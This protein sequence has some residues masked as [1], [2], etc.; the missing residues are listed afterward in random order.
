MA[1]PS[2]SGADILAEWRDAGCSRTWPGT[3]SGTPALLLADGTGGRVARPVTRPGQDRDSLEAGEGGGNDPCHLHCWEGQCGGSSLHRV[4]GSREG[5]ASASSGSKGQERTALGLPGWTRRG[6]GHG[7]HCVMP[8]WAQPQG[9]PGSPSRDSFQGTA[10]SKREDGEKRAAASAHP[11]PAP[12]PSPAGTARAQLPTP[13]LTPKTPRA[14]VTQP[15]TP[16]ARDLPAPP[17]S[18]QAAQIFLPPAPLHSPRHSFWGLP[19]TPHF[20]AGSALEQGFGCGQDSGDFRDF[21][22]ASPPFA[23]PCPSPHPPALITIGGEEAAPGAGER[24]RGHPRTPP[25]LR[26][27]AGGGRGSGHRRCPQPSTSSPGSTSPSCFFPLVSSLAGF[28]WGT[29]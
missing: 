24:P 22:A 25:S 12:L 11:S 3:T 20:G 8:G 28:T 14:G 26:G 2:K 13:P 29:F 9:S 1:H 6:T 16:T 19:R 18:F 10:Q 27:A 17:G 21:P 15:P 4:T 7:G 23:P 5:P